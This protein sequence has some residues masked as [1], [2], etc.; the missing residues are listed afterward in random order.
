MIVGKLKSWK[1]TKSF[2]TSCYYIFFLSHDIF[3]NSIQADVMKESTLYSIRVEAGLGDPPTEYTTNDVEA[4]NFVIKHK[5]EFNPHNPTDFI[6]KW[7]EILIYNSGMRT[8][9]FL[10]KVLTN[11]MDASN[12]LQW[13]MKLL[14]KWNTNKELEKLKFLEK[15]D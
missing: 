2:K 5:L 7:R 11:W 3:S 15:H 1:R 6:K 13:I 10:I 12:I 14:D 9:L 4:G 8:E